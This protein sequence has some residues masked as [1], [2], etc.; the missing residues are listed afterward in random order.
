MGVSLS[1]GVSHSSDVAGAVESSLSAIGAINFGKN[2][3]LN[4]KF[5][6]NQQQVTGTVILAAGDYG[7]DKI[8]GGASGGEYTFAESGGL[9][10]FTIA[11]AKSLEQEIDGSDI[12]STDVVL[13][14]EGTAQG[15][16]N[17]G[18][19]G[20]SG[21]VKALGV[22]GGSNVI[23]EFNA[24]TVANIQLEEGTVATK[25]EY[26]SDS[27][28]LYLCQKYLWVIRGRGGT[29]NTFV[30]PG[31]INSSPQFSG[32]L[33]LPKQKRNNN[34]A[35]T[36][37]DLSHLLVDGTGLPIPLTDIFFI[38]ENNNS[39][40]INGNNSG[41]PF[42]AGRASVLTFDSSIGA[43]AFIKFSWEF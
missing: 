36:I 6:I 12:E 8:R 13:S 28:E 23:V 11:S 17:G 3:L 24:G 41:A 18:T 26:R 40:R 16:I 20:N 43:N 19:F 9:T 34:A 10:T 42:I 32:I 7:H 39:L 15:R 2:Y 21:E 37:S 31:F 35:V 14:W 38:N 30:C 22:F 4:S 1:G 33:D 29:G 5:K 27:E 25:L